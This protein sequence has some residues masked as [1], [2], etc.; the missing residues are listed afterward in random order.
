MEWIQVF[1]SNVKEKPGAKPDGRMRQPTGA[2]GKRL[3]E[4]MRDSLKMPSTLKLIRDGDYILIIDDADCRFASYEE[5]L[6]RQASLEEEVKALAGRNIRLRMLLASPEVET[7]FFS[8]WRNGFSHLIQEQLRNQCGWNDSRWTRVSA[9]LRNQL[10]GILKEHGY[11]VETPERFGMPYCESKGTCAY[12]FSAFISSAFERTSVEINDRKII[13]DPPRQ[14][15][16]K[17]AHGSMM[18]RRIDPAAIAQKCKIFFSP[19][20]KE[21]SRLS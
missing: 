15:Y 21:L 16:K 14:E 10:H 8:D 5:M 9:I 13:I 12:K 6:A 20:Y 18:L 19:V 11:S 4:R 3:I 17:D 2:S 7:W 1:P